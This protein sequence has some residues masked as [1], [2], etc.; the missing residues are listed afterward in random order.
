MIPCVAIL[1]M[2]LRRAGWF[3]DD[4]GDCRKCGDNSYAPKAGSTYCT[5]CL[6]DGSNQTFTDDRGDTCYKPIA[7]ADG[8]RCGALRSFGS[9][10]VNDAAQAGSASHS[11]C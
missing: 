11:A 1:E 4:G 6:S 7:S 2:R 3:S 10:F 9:A 5:P 8:T